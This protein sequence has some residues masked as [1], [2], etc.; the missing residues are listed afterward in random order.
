MHPWPLTP[1]APQFPCIQIKVLHSPPVYVSVK[2]LQGLVG[3]LSWWKCFSLGL[4]TWVWSLGPHGRMT[5]LMSVLWDLYYTT[6]IPKLKKQ[7]KK[8]CLEPHLFVASF[9]TERILGNLSLSSAAHWGWVHLCLPAYWLLPQRY[10]QWSI[11]NKVSISRALLILQWTITPTKTA[12]LSQID[13]MWERHFTSHPNVSK[14][15]VKTT[16][17]EDVVQCWGLLSTCRDLGSISTIRPLL[18]TAIPPKHQTRND[19]Y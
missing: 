9:W 4:L 15:L 14:W 12:G 2:L 16:R 7:T 1:P 6:S 13:L 3:W 17:A 19:I 11:L 8:N 10:H 5:E 18:P